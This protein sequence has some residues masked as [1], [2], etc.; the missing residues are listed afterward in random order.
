MGSEDDS[1]F[2][3]DK[4]ILLITNRSKNWLSSKSPNGDWMLT[5]A[6]ALRGNFTKTFGTLPIYY[7]TKNGFKG[8]MSESDGKEADATTDHPLIQLKSNTVVTAEDVIAD[9]DYPKI[10]L[11]IDADPESE[12]QTCQAQKALGL[13][14]GSHK[15]LVSLVGEELLAPVTHTEDGDMKSY[16]E[17]NLHQLFDVIKKEAMLQTYKSIQSMTV[18]ILQYKFDWSLNCAVNAKRMNAL[19]AHLKLLSIEITMSQQVLVL[20]TNIEYAATQTWGTKIFRVSLCLPTIT[21][22]VRRPRP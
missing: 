19:I 3:A 16:N 20:M 15:N 5:D 13:R 10:L 7:D 1:I 21:N 2:A 22:I 8:I 6:L 9:P 17:W 12:R 14:M 4:M 18:M 11:K